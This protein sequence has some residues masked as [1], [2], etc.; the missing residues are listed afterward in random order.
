MLLGKNLGELAVLRNK[1]SFIFFT[2]VRTRQYSENDFQQP[3]Q[4]QI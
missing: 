1:H 3:L 2:V 4:H